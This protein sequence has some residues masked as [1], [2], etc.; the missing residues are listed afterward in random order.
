MNALALEIA[1]EEVEPLPLHRSSH[2]LRISE[3]ASALATVYG[4]GPLHVE[5]EGERW[6]FAWVC[7]SAPLTGTEL[8]V[9]I[10]DTEAVVGLE[11]LSA[12]GAAAEIRSVVPAALHAPYLNGLGTAAWSA[13]EGLTEC[14]FEVLEVRVDQPLFP[15]A[16]S[17]GFEVGR[18]T[19]PAT[20]GLLRIVDGDIRRDAELR[21]VLA[22]ASLREMSATARLSDLPLLWTAEVARTRVSLGEFRAIEV[23]DVVVLEEAKMTPAGLHCRLNAGVTRRSVGRVLLLKGGQ[24]Q[25]VQF[26][27]R[28]DS[29]MSIDTEAAASSVASFDDVAVN[30]RFEV[31][32]WNAPLAEVGK[33]APGAVVDLGQ[34]VDE[35]TVS[36]WVDQRCIGKGQLVAIGERLGVRLLSVYTREHA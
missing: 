10:G 28:G 26:G 14:S 9:R 20:R 19:G 18:E 35:Q 15:D 27:G 3:A 17:L 16:H 32:Q 36:V 4:C 11:S 25:I 5:I 2:L 29:D 13:L 6:R 30:L 21:R 12:F 34:R 22:V 1:S 8:R 33:L 31:A 23:H 7:Q 24:L